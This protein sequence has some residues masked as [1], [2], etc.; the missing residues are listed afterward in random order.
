ME[1]KRDRLVISSNELS[2]PDV[3]IRVEKMRAAQAMQLVQAAGPTSATVSRSGKWWHRTLFTMAI[4][5][6]FGGVVG[7]ILA[8]VISRPDSPNAPFAD[9]PAMATTL[10]TVLIALG[11]GSV[12][13]S[14]DGILIRSVAK[15]GR[16]L[17]V[18]VPVLLV[19]GAVGGF[20]AQKYIYAPMVKDLVDRALRE[21]SS[22]AEFVRIVTNGLHVPR[23]VG[24]AVMGA[25][26]GLALGA[27]SRSGR[28][29]INGAVGGAVGGFLG[30]FLFDYV[31]QALG[32]N[33]SGVWPRLVA[34][35]LTGVVAGFGIGLVETARKEYWLEI[36]SGGMAGKQFI[37]YHD[38]TL[39]GSEADC[40]V[41]LIKDPM[42][43]PRQMSLVNSTR[44]MTLTNLSVDRPVLVNGRP[45]QSEL[46]HDGDT[47]QVGTTMLRFGEKR[48][49]AP[50]V[51]GVAPG[52]FGPG[53]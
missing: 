51:Q 48:P 9:N 21:A 13:A 53:R 5:G 22:E 32:E 50:T 30:G 25:I 10:F 23:G 11:I 3:D 24:F 31:G 12:I 40:Q 16:A 49:N 26:L 37:L 15:V 33:A 38:E 43:A 46:I 35:A 19:G 7:A 2:T 14:W 28:R 47:V 18:A 45:A 29:A 39:I 41:T 27:V 52:T 4:A 6:L 17:V 1:A 36:L 20:V 44:G 8:E 34:V 42:I